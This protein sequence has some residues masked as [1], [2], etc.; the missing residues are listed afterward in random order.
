MRYWILR[1]FYNIEVKW[2]TLWKGAVE[3][4]GLKW[5]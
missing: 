5:H 2:L 1:L 4:Q 3:N